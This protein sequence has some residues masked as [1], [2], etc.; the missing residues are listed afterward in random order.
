MGIGMVIA[1]GCP[2]RLITRIAEGDG[3]ALSAM[4]GFVAGIVVFAYAMP[5][6]YEFFN[7]LTFSSD[8]FITDFFK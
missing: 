6:M 3:T 4:L 8:F 5:Y 2:F 1:A 7:N